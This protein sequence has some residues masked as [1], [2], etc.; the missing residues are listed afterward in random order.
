VVKSETK[1]VTT[2]VKTLDD[3]H[4]KVVPVGGNGWA[5]SSVNAVI[6]RTN[7]VVTQ[8][9]TQY[10]AYYDG[11]TN[12]VL[13]KR[14][15]GTSTWQINKTQY[16]GNAKDAHNSI[17]IAVDGKG[18]LHVVWD[19]HNQA[20]HY[21]RGTKPGS[22]EL[23]GQMPMTGDKEGS[24]TY[25]QFYNLPDGD[26]LFSY[27][28]GSSGDGDV[29]LNRYDVQTGKWQVVT[30]PL[31]EGEGK[32]N[33]YINQMA[34]DGKGGWHLSWCWRET[35]DVATNHDVCYAYSPDEG[36]TWQKSTG[37]KYSLPITAATAEVA[38]TVPPNSELMNQTSMTTDGGNHPVIVTYWRPQNTEVPQYQLVWHD[39]KKWRNSQAGKRTLGFRLSGGGTKRIPIS[40]PQVVAGNK[41]EIY[42]IFRDEERGS[43]V[44][45]AISKAADHADWRIVDLYNGQEPI[46]G[47]VGV[48]TWS[49]QAEFKDIKVVKGNQTLYSSD[50]SKG[51][52]GWK[53]AG[54]KW[55]VV[56]GVLRQ[57]G[58]ENSTRALVGD[59]NW[60]D[61]T[62][63]LK[64]RKLSGKEGF[65]IRFGVP[66]DD[67]TSWWNLG[68]WGNTKHG[69]EFPGGSASQVPGKIE[70]NRW[71]DI[72]IEVQG[73][74]VK[75]YL[76]DKLVQQ[77]A[78]SSAWEPSYDPAVWKSKR[79]LHLFWENVGQGDAESLQNI[80]PQPV[81]VLEW[82]P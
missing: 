1:T 47:M 67:T 54:G 41:N 40:R 68:G 28:E 37:A 77:A 30:H 50:F 78:R 64:A 15:I 2:A 25:P 44:S 81:R 59:V 61:Y 17:S 51:M 48:G 11:D 7:S 21:A 73:A 23:T 71:Y 52:E 43:D 69:L 31:V 82:T 39:G 42:V 80:A 33:A 60:S 3:A 34:I 9:D 65:L 10:V 8:G 70:T 24:V 49:T 16:T 14:K 35:P 66:G 46:R 4:I 36:K 6:F 74:S 62:F 38:W 26:L 76:D 5:R 45:V 32:R 55:E 18:V 58:T 56:D 57:T 19:L 13:A 53:T 63:T 12:V 20:I 27:R 72:R 22:L 75:C 79:Q 29:M